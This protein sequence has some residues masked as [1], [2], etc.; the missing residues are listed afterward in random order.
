MFE[1]IKIAQRPSLADAQ[2]RVPTKTAFN[3]EIY[4]NLNVAI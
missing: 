3:L 2:K 4:I 1:T